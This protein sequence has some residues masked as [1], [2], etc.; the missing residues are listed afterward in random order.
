[1]NA[2][3][4][5]EWIL[6][7]IRQHQENCPKLRQMKSCLQSGTPT[8]KTND[9]ELKA[10]SNELLCC[11]LGKDGVYFVVETAMRKHSNNYSPQ[12][13]SKSAGHDAR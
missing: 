9:L 4:P 12:L 7:Y 8:I 3:E 1:M 11:F 6:E 2:Q 5:G 13:D 10:L